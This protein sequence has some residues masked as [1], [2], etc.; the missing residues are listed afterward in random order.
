MQGTMEPEHL[1]VLAVAIVVT[2]AW[3]LG[4]R[5]AL[6]T[7]AATEGAWIESAKQTAL[8]AEQNELIK[9]QGDLL[10]R[11]AKGSAPGST[12]ESAAG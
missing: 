3:M 2:L 12:T 11:I 9:K 6:R 4:V 1:V 10:A 8:L 5:A 7:A